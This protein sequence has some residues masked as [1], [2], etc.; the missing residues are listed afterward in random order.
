MTLA[1]RGMGS[2][3]LLST[4][5]LGN[6]NEFFEGGTAKQKMIPNWRVNGYLR[7]MSNVIEQDISKRDYLKDNNQIT[8]AQVIRALKDS[9]NIISLVKAELGVLAPEARRLIRERAQKQIEAMRMNRI[10]EINNHAISM[11]LIMLGAEDDC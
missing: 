2:A 11:I 6:Y 5:G 10:N 7:K 3:C 4:F 8:S 1:T 9:D